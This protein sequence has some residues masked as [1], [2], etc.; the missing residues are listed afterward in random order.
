[1]SGSDPLI[2][3]TKL[4]IDEI[5]PDFR[6][7]WSS[8]EERDTVAH[9]PHGKMLPVWVTVTW[10]DQTGR[11]MLLRMTSWHVRNWRQVQDRREK[12]ILYATGKLAELHAQSSLEASL[13]LALEAGAKLLSTPALCIYRTH[14][15][16][17]ALVLVQTH[18]EQMASMPGT[19][20]LDEPDLQSDPS[21]WLKSRRPIT[22]IQQAARNLGLASLIT[23]PIQLNGTRMGLL[24]AAD[25]P[26]R[27]AHNIAGNL[28]ILA[29]YIAST[30]EYYISA[31]KLQQSDRKCGQLVSIR[32]AIWAS[33]LNGIILLNPAFKI[34]S[35]SSAVESMLGYS[36]REVYGEHIENV[37][38]GLSSLSS[39]LRLA[40]DTGAIQNLAYG[41]AHRR[42]G[43]AF[44][45]RIQI[46]PVIVNGKTSHILLLIE[47]DSEHEEYRN[48]AEQLEQ[49]ALLGE[50]TAIFAHEVRNPINSI[51]TGLQLMEMNLPA[52]DANHDLIERMLSDCSRLTNLM[53]SVLTFSKPMEYHLVPTNLGDIIRKM[54]E[55]WKPR[56]TH[57]NIQL[58]LFIEENLSPIL[59]DESRL[60]QVFTN[61]ISNALSA[62]QNTGGM[63][64]IKVVQTNHQADKTLVSVSIA[65]TGVGISP[66]NL[67]KIFEPFYTTNPQGTGLGLAITK[68]IVLAHKGRIQVTSVAGGTAFTIHFPA[69]E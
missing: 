37:L 5:I 42:S 9:F 30:L 51:S 57:L 64:A 52:E 43:Q 23:V 35:L 62:M 67:E 3:Q 7:D 11:W 53:N 18:G 55:R 19:L 63:L 28:K 14:L 16:Q 24:A 40:C 36:T 49:R 48:H 50:V 1:M 21:V 47:D 66:E 32:E 38:I 60:D 4:I 59:A 39:T 22:K 25:L 56:L 46:S 45:A 13:A 27:E 34:L 17:S 29:D 8:G 54:I 65:D 10:L 12:D 20:P 15:K 33:S 6:G 31:E 44:P 26:P 41:K 2:L 69:R 61:L 68:R 58:R